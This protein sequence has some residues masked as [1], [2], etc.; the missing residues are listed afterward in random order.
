MSDKTAASFK[1]RGTRLAVANSGENPVP[2]KFSR[3]IRGGFD[4]LTDDDF[5]TAP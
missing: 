1:D 4:A 3:T 2:P 5:S